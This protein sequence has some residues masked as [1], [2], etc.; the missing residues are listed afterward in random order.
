M[1]K[2]VCF[3]FFFFLAFSGSLI[4]QFMPQGTW[5]LGSS[6]EPVGFSPYLDANPNLMSLQSKNIESESTFNGGSMQDESKL[7]TS[8]LRTGASYF[9]VD[10]LSVG[11]DL[12]GVATDDEPTAPSGFAISPELRYYFNSP[13][14]LGASTSMSYFDD[15]FIFNTVG[16]SVGYDFLFAS[17]WALEPRLTYSHRLSDERPI[18]RSDGFIAE[19]AFRH[20]PGRKGN[21]VDTANTALKKNNFM[22]G[23]AGFM[24]FGSEHY[25]ALIFV[26]PEV[27]YFLTDSWLVGIGAN[28]FYEKLTIGQGNIFKS[29]TA[30]LKL[31]SRYYV[32]DK[33]FVSGH[34]GNR[35]FDSFTSNGESDDTESD[36]YFY[37]FGVGYSWFVSPSIAVEPSLSWTRT[38]YSVDEVEFDYES[39]SIFTDFNFGIAVQVFLRR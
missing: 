33:F 35:I 34:I 27:G 1:M 20:F 38:H 25:D 31:N 14:Y 37:G 21:A 32:Y 3:S 15:E 22:L 16:G 17:D 5:T 23:G 6:F 36:L 12:L 2:G 19:I 18:F 24:Q 26:N 4:G 30:F 28:Y 10:N 39:E 9:I 11:A 7:F 8:F 13:L 29:S